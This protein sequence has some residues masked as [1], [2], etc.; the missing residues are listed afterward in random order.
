MTAHAFQYQPTGLESDI[1]PG[2]SLSDWR[3]RMHADDTPATRW[4]FLRQL[5]YGRSY[6]SHTEATR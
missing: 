2:E 6:A 5:P 3:Q 1:R 4:A